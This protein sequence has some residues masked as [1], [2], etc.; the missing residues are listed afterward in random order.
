[1]DA[2]DLHAHYSKLLDPDN[3]VLKLETKG[4]NTITDDSFFTCGEVMEGISR[5]RNNKAVGNSFINAE[6]LKAMAGPSFI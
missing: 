1:M 5:L 6:L 4:D 2:G 3:V